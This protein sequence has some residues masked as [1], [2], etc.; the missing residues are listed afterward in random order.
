MDSSDLLHPPT[1]AHALT[2]AAKQ[3][4]LH[5]DTRTNP[6]SS[7]NVDATAARAALEVCEKTAALLRAQLTNSQG[8]R[9]DTAPPQPAKR[10]QTVE[11]GDDDGVA[12]SSWTKKVHT[13]QPDG[14]LR[15]AVVPCESRPTLI[16]AAIAVT[17]SDVDILARMQDDLRQ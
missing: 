7:P 15:T 16:D 4:A 13:Q 14:S 1:L 5:Q 9:D 17:D 6:S 11:R 12:A 3:S 8:D 10:R 2:A